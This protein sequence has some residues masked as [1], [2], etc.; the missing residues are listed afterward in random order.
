MNGV[1][2]SKVAL[3]LSERGEELKGSLRTE[4][5]AVDVSRLAAVFGGGGHIRA[6]GFSVPKDMLL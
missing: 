5:A 2:G 3:L 6:A 1:I 4:E